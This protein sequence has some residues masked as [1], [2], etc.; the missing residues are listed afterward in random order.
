M[1][2][3]NLR[4]SAITEQRALRKHHVRHGEIDQL[5]L[6]GLKIIYFLQI[7]HLCSSILRQRRIVTGRTIPLDGIEH[8]HLLFNSYLYTVVLSGDACG[9]LLIC[10]LSSVAV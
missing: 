8:V 4:F 3:C 6:I 2:D 1:F 9:D 7:K 10:F 5:Y